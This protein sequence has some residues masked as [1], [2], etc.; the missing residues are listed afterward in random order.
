MSQW[1]VVA[2]VPAGLSLWWPPFCAGSRSL[3]LQ[4]KACLWIP[5]PLVMRLMHR[6]GGAV[7]VAV[8]IHNEQSTNG[9]LAAFE[10]L[11]DTPIH[12]ALEVNLV[13]MRGLAC[14]LDRVHNRGNAAGLM[15]VFDWQLLLLGHATYVKYVCNRRALPDV[16][17]CS[18]EA[19]K[20][21]LRSEVALFDKTETWQ[22]TLQVDL[23]WPPWCIY[24]E[25]I[26]EAS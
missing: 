13:I 4:G 10:L 17:Q 25:T 3:S 9:Y 23:S 14:G 11:K 5:R 7:P 26:N 21:C 20:E 16:D 18:R 24:W 12:S 2:A 1:A 6:L 15:L 19:P 8:L 22:Q